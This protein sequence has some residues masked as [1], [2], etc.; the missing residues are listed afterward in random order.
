[1]PKWFS[2]GRLCTPVC[3]HL[4]AGT[5]ATVGITWL[6][7]SRA[8]IRLWFEQ[9]RSLVVLV[10]RVWGELSLSANA[11]R[12]A[13]PLEWTY[14]IKLQVLNQSAPNFGKAYPSLVLRE[15]GT[16]GV[17]T[18]ICTS[19]A[20]SSERAV[21]LVCGDHSQRWVR[22]GGEPEAGKGGEDRFHLAL[23]Q[24]GREALVGLSSTPNTGNTTGD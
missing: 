21:S 6:R 24:Q 23:L 10:T 2:T 3:P 1:M 19:C 5:E 14:Q 7:A 4:L 20:T 12:H 18:C 9:E 22:R 8:H 13:C 11:Q 16:Y 15:S 17:R